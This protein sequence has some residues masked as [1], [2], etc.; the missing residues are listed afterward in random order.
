MVEV[1]GEKACQINVQDPAHRRV[2]TWV[3]MQGSQCRENKEREVEEKKGRK[4]TSSHREGNLTHNPHL[5]RQGSSLIATFTLH[6]D[7]G[8][9]CYMNTMTEYS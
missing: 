9:S 1:Y 7:L 2:Y 4:K 6:K 3:T 8:F 5:T